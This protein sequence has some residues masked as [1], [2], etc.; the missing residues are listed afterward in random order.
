MKVKDTTPLPPVTQKIPSRAPIIIKPRPTFSRSPIPVQPQF[1]QRPLHTFSKPPTPVKRPQP[2]FKQQSQKPTP[3]PRPNPGFIQRP[4]PPNQVQ[5]QQFRPL[6]QPLQ[7]PSINQPNRPPPPGSIL[8][9]I[10]VPDPSR[11]SLPAQRPNPH[12]LRPNQWPGAQQAVPGGQ[13]VRLGTQ[14]PRHWPPPNQFLQPP[15]PK[16]F[17]DRSGTNPKKELGFVESIGQT[18][19]NTFSSLFRWG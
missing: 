4:P 19:I 15:P 5:P 12:L 16:Q 11:V 3:T 8:K 9:P 18:A 10:F 6:T 1:Q 13:V 2:Q 7:R 14:P 17:I